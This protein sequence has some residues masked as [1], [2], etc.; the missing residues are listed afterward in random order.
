MM[1]EFPLEKILTCSARD[2]VESVGKSLR[3]YEMVGVQGDLLLGG[4]RD[5]FLNRIPNDAEVV[6]DYRLAVDDITILYS[7]T[8]LIPKKK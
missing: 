5:N 6:T 1:E 4:T 3:D 2:Y 7:G 8:A